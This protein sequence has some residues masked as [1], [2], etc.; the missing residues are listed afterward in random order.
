M[1][2]II[3]T[4]HTKG[5]GQAIYN[6]FLSDPDNTVVGCSRTNGF[7]IFDSVKRTEIVALAKDADIFVNNAYS[8]FDDSQTLLLEELVWAWHGQDKTII[9]IS[10]IADVSTNLLKEYPQYTKT[11]TKLD[12]FCTSRIFN[13]PH[14]INLKPGSVQT[15]KNKT[16]VI[17]A[18]T[19][20]QL[21]D[22]VDFCVKSPLRITTLTFSHKI[23]APVNTAS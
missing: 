22:V 7:D 11:K 14:I 8:L 6:Y 16:N 9:N 3:V 20:D 4:G 10:S 23:P 21:V 2:K 15:D 12:Q 18:M 13:R 1:K 5:I 17:N 19:L